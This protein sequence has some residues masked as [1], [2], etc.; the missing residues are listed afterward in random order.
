VAAKKVKN[1]IIITINCIIVSQVIFPSHS[2]LLKFIIVNM[3]IPKYLFEM[4]AMSAK[5]GLMM[6][7]CDY[8]SLANF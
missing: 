1:K 6:G 4:P 3:S 8:D 2:E 5:G 7:C